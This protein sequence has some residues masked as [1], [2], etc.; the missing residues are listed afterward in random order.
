[1]RQ[2]LTTI[3]SLDTAPAQVLINAVIG[4]VTLTDST[5]F[6]IDWTR[7]SSNA[8]TGPAR[9]SSRFLP[10]GL[11]DPD[12]G[13]ATTGS[14][15]VLTRTFMDGS[16]VIDATLNAIAQDNEVTLLARPALLAT[17]NQEGEFKVGQR[18]PVNL[19]VTVGLGGAQTQNIQ[20]EDVGIRMCISPRINDDGFVNLQIAQK[21]SSVL[22]SSGG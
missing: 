8:A 10:G 13:L 4:Q 19:G 22:N 16:A 17:N 21:L 20:Y 7:V 5:E 15:L 18:V 14:G 6:G 12:T 11:L 9:L 3:G 2:L 1:Y